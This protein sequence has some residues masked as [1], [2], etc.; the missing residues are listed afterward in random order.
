MALTDGGFTKKLHSLP[1]V[2][3]TPEVLLHQTI[4]KLPR[5]KAIS[6]IIQWDDGSFDADW[7]TMLMT[8]LITAATVLRLEAENELQG[9]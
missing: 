2:D 6:L 3:R 9:R 1:G 7:S 4:E 5:I 8:E